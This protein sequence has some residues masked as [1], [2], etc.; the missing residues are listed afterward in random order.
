ML[1]AQRHTAAPARGF[2]LLEIALVLVVV[3]ILLAIGL[4]S[5]S[6]FAESRRYSKTN[7][8]LMQMKNCLVRCIVFTEHYPRQEDFEH[9]RDLTGKD[10]W[11]GDI[12]WIVGVNN[13]GT[14]LDKTHA[15]VTD[16]ARNQ[17]AETLHSSH[18]VI[19][20]NGNFTNVAFALVSLGAN[21]TA[22]NA[23]YGA[24]NS[25]DWFVLSAV[26]PN[27]S[28]ASDDLVLV[29]TGYELAAIIKNAV[30]P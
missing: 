18:K 10:A 28:T 22:D 5:W 1:R 14:R 26:D 4:L 25:A 3:G 24:L 23:T 11:G 7:S 21:G 30:G 20:A 17:T 6:S 2:T 8:Q 29:V 16:E 27:F 15:V 13:A 19:T 9:C 12:K